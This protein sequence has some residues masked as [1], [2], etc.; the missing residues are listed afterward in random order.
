MM[1]LGIL[2]TGLLLTGCRSEPLKFEEFKHVN[3]TSKK[4]VDVYR[5]GDMVT[6]VFSGSIGS[7]PLI[8]VHQETIKED[9]TITP[10]FVGSVVAAGKTPGDLQKELQEKYDKLFNT[11][12][13]TVISK[14]RYY[15]VTGEVKNPGPEPYLGETDIIKAIS[16]AGDF[17]D[18]ASKR[19]VRLTR[20][21][22]RTQIV[23]VKKILD[24]P[25]FD[26]PVY[27]GD[28]IYVPRKIL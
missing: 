2:W 27:P 4:M 23:N 5:V 8:P 14:E 20:A 21:S 6:I 7:E 3:D 15:Y 12:T 26:V 22:G 13:V 11:L 17:T 16:A 10:T 19:K 24:D 28:K 1:L 9:G 18:F 25:Q